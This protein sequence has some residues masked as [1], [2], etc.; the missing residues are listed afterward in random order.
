MKNMD[1][2]TVLC[3]TAIVLL[4]MASRSPAS[5]GF[6]TQK[7]PH[8]VGVLTR[9]PGDDNRLALTI[10]DGVS[11]QVVG[12]FADFCR[13]SGIRL[14]FFVNG[15]NSSWSVNAPALRPMV[16]SG[17]IQMGN[18][19]WSHPDITRISSAAVA[20]QI[21]RNADFLRNTY[22]VDGTPYFRPPY[23]RHTPATDRIA[24]DEG[25][26][27]ITLWSGSMGDDVPISDA[28]LIAAAQKS[29]WPQQ[30][31][32]GHANR[33]TVTHCFPQLLDIVHS[34]NLQ[35]VTLNDVFA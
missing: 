16:D 32:L 14:T 13:D 2:R 4:A 17:Q 21:R 8:P 31:V 3:G 22:G 27:T 1:R 6:P 28:G 25:Y 12:A 7:V 20:S 33:P 35:T 34:R 23:G 26:A 18:H 15:A 9:L 19:T 5:R 24:A 29:L 11:V 30:I 10:D